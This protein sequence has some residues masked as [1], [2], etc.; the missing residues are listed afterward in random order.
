MMRSEVEEKIKAA[1][2]DAFRTRGDL[3]QMFKYQLDDNLSKYVG[4]G[5]LDEA[6]SKIID[7]FDSQSRLDELVIAAIMANPTNDSLNNLAN[8]INDIF[9]CSDNSR[10][11]QTFS[12]DLLS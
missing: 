10:K 6:I 4:D 8:E 1:I 11:T 9:P 7:K 12:I 2:Q 5:G 3:E